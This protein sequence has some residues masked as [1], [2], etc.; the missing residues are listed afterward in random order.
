MMQSFSLI[1]EGDASGYSAYV[2]ELPAIL[3]TAD[4]MEGLER[5]AKEAI[6]AYLEERD[7]DSSTPLSD[8]H[9]NLSKQPA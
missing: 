3:V 1:V 2:P 8:I 7:G 6:R 9:L 5:V 4:T